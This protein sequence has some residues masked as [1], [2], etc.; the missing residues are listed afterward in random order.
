MQTDRVEYPKTFVALPRTEWNDVLN[1]YRIPLGEYDYKRMLFAKEF[2]YT[3]AEFNNMY[4]FTIVR[5]PY[6]R[7]VSAWKYLLRQRSYHPKKL[8][9]RYDFHR[10]LKE[11]PVLWEEK[12]DRHIATHTAP[13]WGDITD[14]NGIQLVDFVAKLEHIENDMKFICERLGWEFK[15][16]KHINKNREDRAY[17]KHYNNKTRKLVEE[18]YRDDI[19]QLGYSF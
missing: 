11:L 16:F 5:N 17:R 15:S 2:L 4:K 13:V 14:K 8:W 10:F 6:D 12:Y 1:N 7:I 19:E 18:L 9:M 3:E